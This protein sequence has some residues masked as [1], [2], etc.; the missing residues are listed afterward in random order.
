MTADAAS[1]L[2][3]APTPQPGSPIPGS[4]L[5]AYTR[6]LSYDYGV[7]HLARLTALIAYVLLVSALVLG[8]ILRMRYFQRIVN[9]PTVYGAHMT[10]ALSAL[11][12]GALHGLTFLYQPVWDIGS[13]DLIVP[14]AGGLQRV[15]VG[16]GVMGLELAI[17]VG[18]SVWLQRRLG[19]RRWLRFHQLGY[20]A[21]ALIWLHIFT[22]HPEPRH[23][24]LVA[25][26]VAAGAG[27]CLFAFVIRV[28]PSRS[29]LLNYPGSQVR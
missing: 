9:R 16:L 2:T 20:L 18:C 28:L 1:R 13:L 12:F 27:A 10:V 6:H 5:D 3:S 29:R 7:H 14:F 17:A 19:Y 25:V 26:G 24:D 21:F 15:P 23:F 4:A 22:V 11:I 8:T